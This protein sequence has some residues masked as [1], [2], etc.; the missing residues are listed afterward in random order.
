MTSIIYFS[1]SNGI[2]QNGIHIISNDKSTVENFVYNQIKPLCEQFNCAYFIQGFQVHDHA[3]SWAFVEF[4][5]SQNNE[6][7]LKVIDDFSNKYLDKDVYYKNKIFDYSEVAKEL[8]TSLHL[9]K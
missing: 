9:F 1:N 3:P 2:H 6:K 5:E 8:L 4:F 7:V